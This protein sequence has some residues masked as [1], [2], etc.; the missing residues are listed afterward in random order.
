MSFQGKILGLKTHLSWDF[1]CLAFRKTAVLSVVFS[2]CHTA[3]NMMHA[4]IR[5]S[6]EPRA[7]LMSHSLRKS[8]T[9]TMTLRP[10]GPKTSEDHSIF[11]YTKIQ[12]KYAVEL[13][14]I[15]MN[16]DPIDFPNTHSPSYCVRFTLSCYSK[17]KL[18]IISSKSTVILSLFFLSTKTHHIHTIFLDF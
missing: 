8:F 17:D 3:P 2:P 9:F 1:L 7:S 16:P 11:N 13:I 6:C 12:S 15:N 10:H 5:T 14:K 18:F 4:I